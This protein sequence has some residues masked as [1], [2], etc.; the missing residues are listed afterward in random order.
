[1]TFAIS[2]AQLKPPGY[3]IRRANG[4]FPAPYPADCEQLKQVTR[5]YHLLGIFLAKVLQ[6]GRLVDLPLARPLLKLMCSK[7]GAHQCTRTQY[8]FNL[9]N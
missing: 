7:V 5:L 9:L 3:Y 2:C 8:L 1:M 6:D 4:L